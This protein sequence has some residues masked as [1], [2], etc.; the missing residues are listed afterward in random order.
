MDIPQELLETACPSINYR[1]RSEILG[2][3]INS[4]EM[5]QLQAKILVDEWVQ[6]I[7][8][9]LQADDWIGRDFHGEH[10]DD[11]TT[12]YKGKLV[13]KPGI[14][15]P[16][17]YHLRLLAFTHSWRNKE[18]YRKLADGIQRLVYLSPMPYVLL[19]HKSQ[20]V[21]PASFCM[22]DFNPDILKLDDAGWMVW[23]HRMELLARLGVIHMVPALVD[24]VNKL[25]DLLN[26]EQGWFSKRLSHE[27]FRKW[28]A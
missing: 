9:W 16:C 25:N 12:A 22:L 5:V 1:I 10:S 28:G 23:F 3:S 27:Y 18:N 7:F 20:L 13:Y 11:V 19:K 2:E 17:I 21:A 6:K 26:C 14:V 4:P 15:W 24:Q 8:S